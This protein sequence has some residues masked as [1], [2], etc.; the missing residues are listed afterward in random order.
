MVESQNTSD[1]VSQLRVQLVAERRDNAHLR[2]I[3]QTRQ[4]LNEN[5]RTDMKE[6][7]Q[8]VARL[9]STTHVSLF[10]SKLP[11]EVRLRIYRFLLVNPELG[12]TT[13]L[14][15]KTDY[16]KYVLFGLSPAVLRTCKAIHE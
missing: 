4:K 5:L 1:E 13:S 3:L 6:A 8:L 7:E 16:G 10:I 12:E 9:T 15:K 2:D 14:G 11:L